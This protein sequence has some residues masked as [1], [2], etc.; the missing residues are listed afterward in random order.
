M[1][2]KSSPKSPA[3]SQSISPRSVDPRVHY[4]VAATAALMQRPLMDDAVCGCAAAILKQIPDIQSSESAIKSAWQSVYDNGWL[5]LENKQPRKFRFVDTWRTTAVWNAARAG[6]LKAVGEE[7][8][9]GPNAYNQKNMAAHRLYDPTGDMERRGLYYLF[10]GELK[11]LTQVEELWLSGSIRHQ[12][13]YKQSF[14]HRL[15]ADPFS[16][17]IIRWLPPHIESW[18]ADWWIAWVR[19]GHILPDRMNDY[20]RSRAQEE[21]APESVRLCAAWISFW[22]GK[23]ADAK[24]F[25]AGLPTQDAKMMPAMCSAARGD[26]VAIA[27]FEEQ[28]ASLKASNKKAV[29]LLPEIVALYGFTLIR[30]RQPNDLVVA[31]KLIADAAKKWKSSVLVQS[32]KV[33]LS[34]LTGAGWDEL[35]GTPGVGSSALSRLVAHLVDFIVTD[36]RSQY[37]AGEIDFAT[38]QVDQR[39]FRWIYANLLAIKLRL[40]P[41]AGSLAGQV[42]RYYADLEIEQWLCDRVES[43]PIWEQQLDTLEALLTTAVAEETNR[44]ARIAWVAQYTADGWVVGA[45]EQKRLLKGDGWTKGTQVSLSRLKGTTSAPPE[46]LTDQDKMVCALIQ[47]PYWGGPCFLD[48]AEVFKAL[49]GHPAVF[50]GST[51]HDPVEVTRGEVSLSITKKKSGYQVQLIPS[52]PPHETTLVVAEDRRLILYEL[53]ER[54]ARAAAFLGKGLAVPAEAETRIKSLLPRLAELG[55]VHSAVDGTGTD[56]ATVIGDPRPRVLLVPRGAGLVVDLRVRP[57]GEGTPAFIPGHGGKTVMLDVSGERKMCTRTLKQEVELAKAVV[58]A[59]STLVSPDP[60]DDGWTWELTDPVAALELLSELG[61]LKESVVLEW[62]EGKKLTPPTEVSTRSLHINIRTKSDYFAASANV[63]LDDGALLDFGA[64]I[65]AY[66]N[67]GQG[68]F[69]VMDNDRVIALSEQLRRT[70]EDLDTLWEKTSGGYRFSPVQALALQP[71]L[72]QIDHVDADSSWKKWL[73]RLTES[74]QL[75]PEVPPPFRDILRS[76]QIDGFQWLARLAYAQM[77]ACLADDMGLGKTIQVLALLTYR[78]KLGPALVAAPTSVCMNWTDETRKFAPDLRPLLF[79]AGDRAQMIRDAGPGDLIVVSYGLLLSESELL[80][81][82]RFSTIVLD[83]AQWIKNAVAKRTQAAMALQGDFRVITTGTPVENHLGELWN[84]FRFINPGLLGSWK[85]FSTRFAVP[86]ERNND[87][88]AR[89][90]LKTLL[91]PFILRRTKGQVLQELP[92]R[93]EITIQVVPTA[94]ETAFYEALR[95]RAVSALQKNEGAPPGQKQIQ[96]LAELMRLRRACCNPKLVVPDVSISSS[97]LQIFL[98]LVTE[99]LEGSHRALVFSQFVDHLALAKEALD[100]QG[101][102]YQYLDG[103]TPAPDRR[104]RVEAFQRGEGDLFLISLK[105]GGV[106]LNLTGAD[107]VIHLDPWWNPAVED[108]ASDRAHRL[109]QTRPVTIYRLVM[110]DTVESR[111]VDLHRRKRDLATSLLEGTENV[112]KLQYEDLIALLRD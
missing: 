14:A 91:G 57:L 101:V 40:E 61:Q 42:D 53:D 37:Q 26:L 23:W 11:L 22:L 38:K 60:N 90:K 46:S 93:T 48:S 29:V 104:T 15:L 4:V 81:S 39:Y 33:L 10:V 76:Y 9:V 75:S 5:F 24:R 89:R 79:G 17:Q 65:E 43:R 31:E 62:A 44:Q 92:S 47:Q 85:K 55:T 56:Y 18:F 20:F 107:Y 1:K 82:R 3:A 105:A 41:K 30:R 88:T 7:I 80:A 52:F 2:L 98:D 32:L 12:E 64:L 16:E 34:V 69:V 27:E 78:M 74:E 68:R 8:M 96:V 112:G 13:A 86:I 19:S 66:R 72:E 54:K 35:R 73:D 106:G 109:G 6:L 97:K 94:E 25:A 110:Q 63:V 95:I 71:L 102:K 49:I 100:S 84:L 111:I 108:Q 83:E 103:S 50:V 67:R 59:C 45:V 58:E 99:L 70:L 36:G 28:I 77:G 87:K 51:S 21:T